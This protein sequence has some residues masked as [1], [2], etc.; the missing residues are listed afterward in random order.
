MANCA[1]NGL[2]CSAGGDQCLTLTD[3]AGRHVGDETGSGVAHFGPFQVL[4]HLD[5]AMADRLGRAGLRGNQHPA[6]DMR[7]WDGVGF[8]DPDPRLRSQCGKVFR[9]RLQVGVTDGL[10][11]RDHQIHRQAR[12]LRTLSCA[13]SEIYHLLNDVFG[14]KA[15]ETGVLRTAQSVRQMAVS[16]REHTRFRAVPHHFGHRRM[17][18]GVPIGHGEEIANLRQREGH[19]AAGNAPQSAVVRRRLGA[20]GIDRE[21]PGRRGLIRARGRSC[22]ANKHQDGDEI[23]HDS[24]RLLLPE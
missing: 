15:R 7:F 16:A 12:R 20:R 23:P 14:R 4:R 22:Q 9:S 11:D 17:V 21:R 8:D 2:A 6:G 18:V 19:A 10:R 24:S 13:A 1:W 5:D 3:A